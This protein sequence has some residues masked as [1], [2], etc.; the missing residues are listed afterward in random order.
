MTK[1]EDSSVFKLDKRALIPYMDVEELVQ[2]I[3]V[4]HDANL[5]LLQRDGY[6]II[7]ILSDV[8][9]IQGILLS[10]ITLFLSVWNYNQLEDYLATKLYKFGPITRGNT[11]DHG[12]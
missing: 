7:D 1:L 3:Q 5:T 10:G 11:F 6:T 4:D 9:G 8:G 2:G 12:H